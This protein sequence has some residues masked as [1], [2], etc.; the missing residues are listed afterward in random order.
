MKQFHH[1]QATT[2]KPVYPIHKK[3]KFSFCI[4]L[5]FRSFFIPLVVYLSLDNKPNLLSGIIWQVFWLV[6][7]L[8]CTPFMLKGKNPYALLWISIAM[9]IYAGASGFMIF[10]HGFSG[11]W[12]GAVAWIVDFCLLIA[13]NYWLFILLKRLPKMNG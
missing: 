1:T 8:L 4:W 12:T 3:L 6:P 9:L 2:P 11:F 5:F 10:L 7:A 13:I